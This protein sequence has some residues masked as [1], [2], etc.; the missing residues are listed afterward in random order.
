MNKKAMDM[1]FTLLGFVVGG[2]LLIALVIAFAGPAKETGEGFVAKLS[3]LIPGFNKETTLPSSFD[4]ERIDQGSKVEVKPLPYNTNRPMVIVKQ[5][6]G[7]GWNLEYNDLTVTGQMDD[8]EYEEI[9]VVVS[10]ASLANILASDQLNGYISLS[11]REFIHSPAEGLWFEDFKGDLEND[12]GEAFEDTNNNKCWDEGEPV[13][14]IGE[15][16]NVYNGEIVCLEIVRQAI[17]SYLYD[18]ST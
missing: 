15:P 10:H 4:E 11:G 16:N 6:A 13:T 12:L 2:L 18:Q 14:D 1:N 17:L 3:S 8:K 5:E 9:A 7:S